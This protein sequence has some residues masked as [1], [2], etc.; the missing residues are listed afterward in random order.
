[1]SIVCTS[2]RLLAS[3][4]FGGVARSHARAHSRVLSRLASLAINGELASGLTRFL[5]QRHKLVDF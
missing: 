1:M 3:S 4:P 2:T 5:P